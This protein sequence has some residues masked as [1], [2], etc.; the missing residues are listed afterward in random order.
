MR[1]L[2]RA[3]RWAWLVL[4]SWW[5]LS[6]RAALAIE[7]LGG[8]ALEPAKDK[9]DWDQ[10]SIP[11][12]WEAV[13]KNEVAMEAE[14]PS[15]MSVSSG[16]NPPKTAAQLETMYKASNEGKKTFEALRAKQEHAEGGQRGL[17][18]YLS[19]LAPV[20]PEKDI[21]PPG[22]QEGGSRKVVH[23]RDGVAEEVCRQQLVAE[24]V[25]VVAEMPSTPYFAVCVY[26]L[27]EEALVKS[28]TKTILGLED[29]PIRTLSVVSRSSTEAS[30]WVRQRRQQ[31]QQQ[32][33]H[34][35]AL[36]YE[37]QIVPYGVRQV[38]A[39]DFWET[40]ENR[41]A[42][43]TVCVIDSGF[44]ATHEDLQG[45]DVDGSDDKDF[46][47]P[48]F[49][50]GRVSHGTH[51]TGTIAAQD[52]G[53]GVVGVAPEAS[54]YVVRAFTSRG[55]F[56]GSSLVEA[57]NA[58][59]NEGGA[60]IINLSLGGPQPLSA[61]ERAIEKLTEKGILVIAAAGNDGDRS[62]FPSYPAF[63]TTSF[64]IAAVDEYRKIADFSTHNEQ[65]D[66]AGPGVGILS[67]T[68]NYDGSYGVK[69]GTSMAVPHVSGVAALLWSTFPEK[70]AEEIRE[71]MEESAND[72]GACGIDRLFGHGVVDAMA[73]AAYLSDP[74]GARAPET[75]NCTSVEVTVSTD[76][77]GQETTFVIQSMDNRDVI[78]RGGPYQAGVERSYKDAFEIPDG[79]YTISL[80]DA[81]G[82]G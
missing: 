28:L 79:C 77:Y 2:G 18:G 29:D 53:V 10:L 37:G 33:H 4:V 8:V 19:F 80:L 13:V 9:R 47:N 54:I 75:E 40:Y 67:T 30:E 51:T 42:G 71:A 3:R 78:Y 38:R 34:E 57:L 82:D 81:L 61:E 72:S 56:A 76:L 25:E 68:N 43:V 63:Y 23:C 55:Y 46:V 6:A 22:C 15:S 41:G 20:E 1:S 16:T 17:Q 45:I 39:P 32:H 31:K 50:D 60:D 12:Q 35:R 36:Q 64:S 66:V 49:E 24:G 69:D 59:V 21:T 62:N 65:V 27:A 11:P 26:S 48:W 7:K 74:S 14:I 44:R 5:T 52:N 73:A 70:T 58:C